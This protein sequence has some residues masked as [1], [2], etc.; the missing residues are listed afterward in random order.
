VIH[1]NSPREDK[2]FMPINC[3]GMTET[4]LE[5]ELFGH[6]KGSFT[7]AIRD[8]KGLFEVSDQGTVFLDEIA[9]MSPALQVKF[10]RVLQEGTFLPVGGTDPRKVD[11]RIISATNKNLK[12]LVAKGDFREDLY[13]RLNVIKIALPPLRKRQEDIP[14]LVEHFI[15]TMESARKKNIVGVRNDALKYLLNYNWPGN[16][17]ELQNVLERAIALASTKYVTREDLPEEIIKRQEK[18]PYPMDIHH[19]FEEVKKEYFYRLLTET[20]GNV[21][22]SA[23]RAQ[24]DRSTF[25]RFLKKYHLK[26][27]DFKESNP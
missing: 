27:S 17:R 8:K 10:L 12:E 9:E 2:L 14:L 19:S 18:M 22:Q 23:Q 3:G 25:Q 13:Y 26:A 11:V 4:L 1:Y 5:S 16:I 24:L 21:T 15:K 20:R 6:I 7:G